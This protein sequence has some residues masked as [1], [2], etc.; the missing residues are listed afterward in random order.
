MLALQGAVDA[1]TGEMRSY[2]AGIAG[3]ILLGVMLGMLILASVSAIKAFK[4]GRRALKEQKHDYSR[5]L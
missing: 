3:L 1:E 4:L 2:F 5:D